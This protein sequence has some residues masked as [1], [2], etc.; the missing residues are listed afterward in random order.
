M[1]SCVMYFRLKLNVYSQ[2]TVMALNFVYWDF[3]SFHKSCEND[4]FTFIFNAKGFM[5]FNGSRETTEVRI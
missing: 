1:T 5:V 2:E 4:E 3:I